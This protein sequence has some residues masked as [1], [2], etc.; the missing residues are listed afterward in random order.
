MNSPKET[1]KNARV[2]L[3]LIWIVGEINDYVRNNHR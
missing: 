1:F 3:S 2:I